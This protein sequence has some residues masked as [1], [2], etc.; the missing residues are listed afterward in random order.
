MFIL[1]YRE[2][3]LIQSKCF[4]SK[5]HNYMKLKGFSLLELLVVLAVMGVMMG[6]LGFSFLDNN[7]SDLGDSQRSLISFLKQNPLQFLQELSQGSLYLEKTITQKNIYVRF[8]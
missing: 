4:Y 2:I 5:S 1:E 3:F 8:S 6:A 7:S